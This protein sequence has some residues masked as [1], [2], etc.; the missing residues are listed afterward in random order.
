VRPSRAPRPDVAPR[1]TRPT[2]SARGGGPLTTRAALLA[3]VVCTLV[4][5]AALPLRA[6]LAQRAEIAELEQ[7]QAAARERVASLEEQKR[8]LEDPAFLAAE[9][10][11]R[12]HM[13]RPGEVSYVL[14]T[15]PPAPPAEEGA[16]EPEGGPA[17]PWWSQVWAGVAEADRSPAEPEADVAPGPAPAEPPAEEPAP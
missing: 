8:Q 4:F 6:F 3:L 17:A 7:A 1:A 9:A 15:P 12:L 14:V 5:S 16:P 13:A 2:V 11:R 10:R